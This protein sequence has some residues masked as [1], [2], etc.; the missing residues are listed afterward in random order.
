MA[1]YQHVG[2]KWLIPYYGIHQ[3]I[4]NVRDNGYQ[5][6]DLSAGLFGFKDTRN[7]NLQEDEKVLG[8]V[9]I[10][11]RDEYLQDREHT[12]MREDTAY[13]R[14]VNDMRSAGLNPYTVG[15]SPAASSS[16]SVGENT[17]ATQLQMLGYVLDLKNLDIKNK[18]LAN[19]ILSSILGFVGGSVARS[20]V[21]SSAKSSATK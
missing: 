3:M 8:Q 14:A 13:Q 4:Q 16:S 7:N 1:N 5:F 21:K 10:S 20:S 19:T 6:G 17:I 11:S 15:S 9:A 18:Q 2:W 12:E